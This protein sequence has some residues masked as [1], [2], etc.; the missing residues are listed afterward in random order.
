M[1]FGSLSSPFALAGWAYW[2]NRRAEPAA[3]IVAGGFAAWVVAKGVKRLIGRGRP[4]DHDPETNLRLWTEIDGSLGY[5]SGHAAVAMATAGIIHRHGS[6][7]LSTA[8]YGLAGIVALSRVYVG[9][10]LPIDVI[11][12]AA[13]G[14]LVSEAVVAAGRAAISR[15]DPPR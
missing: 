15:R 4:H 7:R 13:L 14:V 9:A 11:G 12:G 10:H 6:P 8:A 3:S 1:Q 2:R 5:V